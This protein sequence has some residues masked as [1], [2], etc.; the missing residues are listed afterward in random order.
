ML[1]R[2]CRE[3]AYL[4]EYKILLDEAGFRFQLEIHTGAV[5]SIIEAAAK[6]T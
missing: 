3:A 6:E 1:N 2:T 5:F 4:P